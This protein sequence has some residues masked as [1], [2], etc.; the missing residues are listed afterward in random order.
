MLGKPEQTSGPFAVR[1]ILQQKNSDRSSVCLRGSGWDNDKTAIQKLLARPLKETELFLTGIDDHGDVPR[2]REK[3]C[4]YEAIVSRQ[5]YTES[6]MCMVPTEKDG[7]R[8]TR[9]GFAGQ[10]SRSVV[11]EGH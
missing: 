11:W 4:V 8:K 1:A 10:G 6:R 3:M 7:L 9:V 5:E 2:L